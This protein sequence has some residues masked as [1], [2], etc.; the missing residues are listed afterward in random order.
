MS[1]LREAREAAGLSQSRLSSLASVPQ[2]LISAHENGRLILYPAA[3]KRIAKVLGVPESE[4]FPTKTL[5][6]R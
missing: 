1:R 6:R 3:R 4:L 5:D 2:S